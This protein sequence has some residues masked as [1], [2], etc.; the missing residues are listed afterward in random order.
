MKTFDFIYDFG[1]PNSYLVHKMMDRI[2]DRTG[3]V[4]VYCPVLLG[5][6]FKLTGNQPPMM[7]FSGVKG[8]MEYERHVMQ[9]FIQRNDIPFQFN[10][11]FPVVTTA[12][13]RG[14]VFAQGRDYEMAYVDCVMEAMW[15]HGK[16][17]NDPAVMAEVLAARGLPAE[18]IMAGVQDQ[19]V[20]DRLIELTSAAV[21]RGVF[22]APMMFVGDEPFF[23]KDSLLEMELVLTGA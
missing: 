23:G 7:A 13:M 1:S 11:H 18:E 9:R 3:A 2:V 10:P 14:A 17:M 12:L 4:P 20:K 6:V 19:G 8:K 16:K 22:G 5:G 21:E 15:L